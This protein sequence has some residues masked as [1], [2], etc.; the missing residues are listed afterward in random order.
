MR[1]VQQYPSLQLGCETEMLRRRTAFSSALS[2]VK[3]V[4]S[5]ATDPGVGDISAKERWVLVVFCLGG[6]TTDS[7]VLCLRLGG[8]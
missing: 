6:T 2:V 1:R 7:R 5:V 3:E 8:R 4:A